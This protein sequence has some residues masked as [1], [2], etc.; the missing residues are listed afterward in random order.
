MHYAAFATFTVAVLAVLNPV[1]NAAIFIGLTANR[2]PSEQRNTAYICS[3][4]VAVIMLISVWAG[5]WMLKAFGISVSAFE[6]AGGLIVLLIGL[7]MIRG[8]QKKHSA[9][10][11]ESAAD[12][13]EA[14]QKESVAV[15]PLAIPI[16]AGPG[17]ISAIIAH[18]S[19][20][21]TAVSQLIESGIVVALALVVGIAFF[22]AP[23]LAKLLGRFG[24]KVVTRIM[25]LIL[26][27]IAFQL[28]IN[29]ML[30]FFPGLAS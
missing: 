24:L 29:G 17:A 8:G 7:D 5:P 14:Q 10:P 13:A 21:P 12:H 28:I 26:A 27:A 1:G 20:F 11:E 19:L 6:I 2:S 9:T 22:L 3:I 30:A 18:A 15:V 25:G 4:A 23:W 16:V